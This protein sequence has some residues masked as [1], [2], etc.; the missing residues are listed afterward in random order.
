MQNESFFNYPHLK[1][2]PQNDEDDATAVK[3]KNKNVDTRDYDEPNVDEERK[4][5]DEGEDDFNED[6]EEVE[7][8]DEVN[9]DETAET[10]VKADHRDIEE[11]TFDR[12]RYLWCQVTFHVRI[13]F[14]LIVL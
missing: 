10:S 9:L 5:A 14:L 3:L 1:F 12:D 6:G 8:G 7:E 4:D 2:I 13:F 11:Y